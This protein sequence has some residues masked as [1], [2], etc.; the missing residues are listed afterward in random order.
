MKILTQVGDIIHMCCVSPEEILLILGIVDT[1]IL[2][3]F[4]ITR[5]YYARKSAKLQEE[6]LRESR[7]YW[8]SWKKRSSNIAEEV[9]E[10]I[11]EEISET[12]GLKVRNN[13]RGNSK[14]KEEKER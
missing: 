13:G 12:L 14:T 3:A 8:G 4:A 6:M 10:G 11:E 5:T 2:G 9:K 1:V 7:A